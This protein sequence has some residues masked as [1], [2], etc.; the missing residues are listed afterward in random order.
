M[1]GSVPLIVPLKGV[2][3]GTFA[4]KQTRKRFSPGIVRR[5]AAKSMHFLKRLVPDEGR[6]PQPEILNGTAPG[7]DGGVPA[8]RSRKKGLPGYNLGNMPI[9]SKEALSIGRCQG[10]A[11]PLSLPPLFSTVPPP[12]SAPRLGS[13]KD[14]AEGLADRFADELLSRPP[15][16]SGCA[17]FDAGRQAPPV[18]SAAGMARLPEG[19]RRFFESR[20]GKGLG[21]VRI[22]DDQEAARGAR[23]MGAEAFTMDRDIWF[24][25]GMFQ[26]GIPSARRLLAH[27][28]GHVIQSAAGTDVGIIRCHPG[29][30]DFNL[31]NSDVGRMIREY[32]SAEHLRVAVP[33]SDPPRF[34]QLVNV[35]AVLRLLAASQRF[36]AL[37]ERIEAAYFGRR[38]TGTLRFEFHLE[39]E[40]P[41][42]FERG[43]GGQPSLVSVY[44]HPGQAATRRLAL[45]VQ[46][47]VHELVHAS[48]RNP[49]RVSV[50]GLGSV[51]VAEARG[52]AEERG[53]RVEEYPIMD[54]IMASGSWR[55]LTLGAQ[56]E[57][58]A[59]IA[60]ITETSVRGSFRSGLPKLTYQEYFIIEEMRNRYRPQGADDAEAHAYARGMVDEA[61]IPEV[62]PGNVARFMVD[63][64]AVGGEPTETARG[65]PERAISA[66]ET[67]A[68][69]TLPP[70]PPPPQHAARAIQCYNRHRRSLAR[71][72]SELQTIH[73]RCVAFIRFVREDFRYR[74]L[75]EQGFE[76]EPADSERRLEAWRTLMDMWSTMQEIHDRR[77]AHQREA[78]SFMAWY[79]Q[80]LQG[81][82]E[83]APP[84]EAPA[85]R[86]ERREA[87]SALRRRDAQAGEQRQAL[88]YFAWVLIAEKMSR[89]WGPFPD[90]DPRVQERHL[91][92]LEEAAGASRTRRGMIS[93]VP[94]LLR[95]IPHP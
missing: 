51:G 49:P 41:T 87:G 24:G 64:R 82:R 72:E 35:D 75:I 88:R 37:A 34:I 26:P 8:P 94:D 12:V 14:D 7:V 86:E 91:Q 53:T 16:F 30:D 84:R 31:L 20:L 10:Q 59:S 65:G 22:H 11:A 89:E 77:V 83:E 67:T 76:P 9:F 13:G 54:E 4:D 45:V 15:V 90:P 38:R 68:L 27:E 40:R 93:G 73:R 85:T 17:A 18:E 39:Q 62:A 3:V 5:D 58:P 2:V 32:L 1:S 6:V 61:G 66:Y 19:E 57:R 29:A 55:T 48:H 69:E 71:A 78:L 33:F 23:I 79:A 52:V 44:V 56:L 70:E 63:W 36:L 60:E 92:F 42:E 81:V 43:R 80:H 46:G 95:G 25:P 47:I 28:L 50:R 21:Q 74:R